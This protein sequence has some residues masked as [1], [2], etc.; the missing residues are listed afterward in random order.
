MDGGTYPGSPLWGTSL[1]AC[2]DFDYDCDGTVTKQYTDRGHCTSW[3]EVCDVAR[4]GWSGSVPECGD[5][6]TF[7]EECATDIEY[8]DFGEYG[9]YGEYGGEFILELCLPEFSTSEI[10]GCR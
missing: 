3:G 7:I 1:N 8:I 2:G 4:I 9:E 10:Q 5:I 6:D